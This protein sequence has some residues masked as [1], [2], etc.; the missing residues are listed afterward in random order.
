[1]SP[2]LLAAAVL[3]AAP[4]AACAPTRSV[5][6]FQIVE[7]KPADIKVGEDTRS[8]VSEKLGSPSMVSTFEPNIW[9]YV[10]S[11]MERRAFLRSRT[12]AREVVAISFDKGTEKVTA[13]RTLGLTDG[14]Q[15]AY[16]DRETPT[17]GRELSVLEQL[18]G[19]VGRVGNVLGQDDTP[20]ER[21]RRGE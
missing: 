10:S 3:L 8:T 19:N 15:I 18:L 5:H 4:L 11:A 20:E 1:M 7:T 16:N 9:F 12:T 13:V 14:K 2:R 6:G 17:R 21:R